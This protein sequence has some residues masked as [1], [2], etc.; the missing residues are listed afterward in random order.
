MRTELSYR[1]VDWQKEEV[2]A[3]RLKGFSGINLT[4][5]F[6]SIATSLVGIFVPIYIWQSTGKLVFIPVYYLIYSLVA[7]LSQIPGAYLIKKIG[8]DWSIVIGTIF[9]AGFMGLLIF[10]ESN[11]LFFWISAISFG[12]CQPFDWLPHYYVISKISKES[13]KFGHAAGAAGLIGRLGGALGPLVG[14]LIIVNWGYES[15]YLLAGGSLILVV[16]C[17]FLDDFKKKNMHVSFDDVKKCMKDKGIVKH[18]FAHGLRVFDMLANL[19]VWPV[20][21][22]TVLGSVKE[23]GSLQT[24]SLVIVVL[25]TYL[26]GKFVDKKKFS[27]MYLGVILIVVGW[28]GRGLFNNSIALGLVNMAYILGVTMLWTPHTAMLFARSNKKYTMEFWLVREIISYSMM[29]LTC[30]VFIGLFSYIKTPVQLR[31][32]IPGLGIFMLLGLKIPKLYKKYMN[33]IGEY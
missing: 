16:L 14:G 6:R 29:F 17:P 8:V 22:F 23:S 28:L 10:A 31:I 33:Y 4:N 19:M 13:K 9:R 21:L 11:H 5:L 26:T 15:L 30:L 7:V 25:V 2:G 32:L 3:I 12:L 18:F 1:D 27:M 20:F 24:I